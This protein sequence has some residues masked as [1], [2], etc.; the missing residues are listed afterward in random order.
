[1]M[2]IAHINGCQEKSLVIHQISHVVVT[3]SSKMQVKYS[4]GHIQRCLAFGDNSVACILDD[5]FLPVT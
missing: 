1:M 4:R 3:R 2:Q 5:T